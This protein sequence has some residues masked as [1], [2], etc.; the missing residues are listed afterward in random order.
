M[1]RLVHWNVGKSAPLKLSRYL[2]TFNVVELVARG[3]L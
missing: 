2:G 1:E 3:T